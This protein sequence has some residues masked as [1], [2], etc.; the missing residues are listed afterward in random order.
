VRKANNLQ[1][2]CADVKKFGDLNPLGPCGPV[3]ACNGAAFFIKISELKKIF[4]ACEVLCI[5]DTYGQ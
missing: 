1:R 5:A 2:S 4:G 3:Q